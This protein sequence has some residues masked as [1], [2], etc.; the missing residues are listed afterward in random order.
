MT[1]TIVGG[2]V[3][4]LALGAH[5]LGSDWSLTIAQRTGWYFNCFVLCC[6]AALV[7]RLHPRWRPPE[8]P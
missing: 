5:A 4:W 7:L 3:L 8:A 1:P 6:L 2:F